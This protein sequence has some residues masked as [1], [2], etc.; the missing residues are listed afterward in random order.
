M[1][2]YDFVTILGVTEIL[3][4]FR[5]VLKGKTGME[6]PE[7]SR[8]EFLE[9]F[10]A[11]NF[12]LSD[13]EDNTSRPLNRGGITYLPL[14]RTLFSELYFRFT[15]FIRL[16]QTK[17]VISMNY[18]SS[19]SSWRR[20]RRVRLELLLTMR[21][22]YSNSSLNP[23]LKFTSSSSRGAEFI[24]ILLPWN[25]SQMIIETVPISM[26]IVI[27]YTMKLSIPLWIWWNV[28]VNWNKNMSRISQWRESHS[29]TNTSIRRKK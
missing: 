15:R 14:L 21:D 5:L 27:N 11:N 25:I 13:A 9:K 26:R 7:S 3:C 23:L 4:S 22:I 12:A 1:G 19:T 16:V 2:R 24:D 6:I 17:K 28:N 29:R 20:M 18:G 10:S 8:L